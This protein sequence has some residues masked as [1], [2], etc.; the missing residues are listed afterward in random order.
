MYRFSLPLRHCLSTE[1]TASIPL[2]RG[3]RYGSSSAADQSDQPASFGY[4]I[5]FTISTRYFSRMEY[6]DSLAHALLAKRS[7]WCEA[8]DRDRDIDSVDEY[9]L[10]GWGAQ[11]LFEVVAEVRVDRRSR[12]FL[13]VRALVRF[14]FILSQVNHDYFHPSTGN[15]DANRGLLTQFYV[16]LYVRLVGT[17][18][19]KAYPRDFTTRSN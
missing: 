4:C 19:R 16:Q 14:P 6:L 18:V 5:I 10:R 2:H 15:R 7:T 12:N 9:T 1:R 11:P 13:V 17:W 3:P 8:R